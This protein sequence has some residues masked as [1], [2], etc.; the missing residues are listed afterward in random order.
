M[1]KSVKKKS[2]AH[3][4]SSEQEKL[5]LN[6]NSRH[7]VKKFFYSTNYQDT[8]YV[9]VEEFIIVEHSYWVTLGFISCNPMYINPRRCAHLYR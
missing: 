6:I 1:K 2:N 7:F 8:H 3:K 4:V 5:S 9:N